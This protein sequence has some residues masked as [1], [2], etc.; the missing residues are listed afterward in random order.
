MQLTL[1]TCAAIAALT[2][3]VV[4]GHRFEKHPSGFMAEFGD[5]P[6]FDHDEME[7][8]ERPGS[9]VPVLDAIVDC[10]GEIKEVCYGGDYFD[11]WEEDD[12]YED[13]GENRKFDDDGDNYDGENRK[14]VELQ[15]SQEE[16][17]STSTESAPNSEGGLDTALTEKPLDAVS[18]EKEGA[19]PKAKSLAG[20][21]AF[22]GR[23]RGDQVH[24]SRGKRPHAH[25][26][27]RGGAGVLGGRIGNKHGPHRNRKLM[28]E[29]VVRSLGNCPNGD[30]E[31]LLEALSPQ[32][33]EMLFKLSAF[34]D[35]MEF[36]EDELG[37][38]KERREW[39]EKDEWKSK[40]YGGQNEHDK[41]YWKESYFHEKDDWWHG[42]HGKEGKWQRGHDYDDR[43]HTK[44]FNEEH[45]THFPRII[46]LGLVAGGVYMAFR[47]CRKN[48]RRVVRNGIVTT[49]EE[50]VQQPLQS[51]IVAANGQPQIVAA[52]AGTPI[53]YPSTAPEPQ[54]SSKT[55][56]S[57]QPSF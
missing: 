39:P 25:G 45:D 47:R 18:L 30:F 34:S 42:P 10:M 54:N 2:P 22:L 37:F 5:K 57:Q 12:F 51:V 41:H 43:W 7:K 53:F 56:S 6:H 3:A 28:K 52:P 40:K 49:E 8:F 16:L 48:S 33:G 1:A 9:D 21:L 15:T 46:L 20:R 24:A 35:M 29:G 4:H 44:H 14:L 27:L 55:S 36:D 38:E 26:G 13:D 31:Y 50:M 23:H 19:P 17:T 11:A 32:C